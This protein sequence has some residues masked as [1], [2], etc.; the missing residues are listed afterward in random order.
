MGQEVFNMAMVYVGP[1]NV[2]NY[3]CLTTDIIAGALPGAQPGRVVFVTDSELWYIVRSD[4]ILVPY[5]LPVEITLNGDVTVGAVSI[6]QPIA[7]SVHVAPFNG[8]ENVA[9]P[10]T[11]VPL[12]GAATYAISLVVVARGTNVGAVYIGDASVDKDT[13]KQLILSPGNSMSLDA[14]LGYKIS[15]HDWYIDADNAN[16]GVDFIYLK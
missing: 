8:T 13:S 7:D 9:V 1:M 16:D 3:T 12:L 2:P 10:G 5:T 14:P 15:L 4:G 11:G 6:D